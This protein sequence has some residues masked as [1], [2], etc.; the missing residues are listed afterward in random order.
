MPNDFKA[1]KKESISFPLLKND[2]YQAELTDVKIE[3]KKKY[4]SED[5]EDKITFEFALLN[6]RDTEGN[7]ARM[8]LLTKNYVPTFLYIS[9]KTGKNWLYKIVEAIMG[10]DLDQEQ[11]A[12][13][14]S[15][16]MLNSMI[17]G[18]VRLLLEKEVSKKDSTKFYSKIA[19]VL[20]AESELSG[21]NDEE[22]AKILEIRANYAIKD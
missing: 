5:F 20:P 13:G 4:Q 18:Q 16:D 11:E 3:P 10:K 15:G 6:G 19:N 9:Q 22:K 17:G 14:I 1:E 2:I 12:E 8:R 7:D 21:L